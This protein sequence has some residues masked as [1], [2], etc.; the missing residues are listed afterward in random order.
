MYTYFRQHVLRTLLWYNTLSVWQDWWLLN[1]A[2]NWMLNLIPTRINI[3]YPAMGVPVYRSV[4]GIFI[5]VSQILTG[6]YRCYIIVRHGPFT[7]YVKVRVAHAPGMPGTFSPKPIVS[8]PGMHHGMCVTHVPWC[9]S[10]SLTR[11]GGENVPGIPGA[12]A[13]RNFTCLARGPF[14]VSAFMY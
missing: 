11:G 4:E 7:R 6:G 1:Q 8:D 12:C 5:W 10:E 13:T 3:I 14:D 9:M 2:G